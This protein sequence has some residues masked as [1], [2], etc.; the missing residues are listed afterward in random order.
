MTGNCPRG[1]GAPDCYAGPKW[2]PNDPMFYLHHTVSL[3]PLPFSLILAVNLPL[4]QM[5]DR[6]WAQWQLAAPE[7]TFSFTG[8]SVRARETYATYQTFPNGGPPFLNV[9]KTCP[10][11]SHC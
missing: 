8:G 11:A 5:V 3:T 9:G 7:N 10:N 2:T 6:L 1:T 4:L